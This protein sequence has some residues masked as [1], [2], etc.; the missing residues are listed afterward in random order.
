MST[1][2]VLVAFDGDLGHADQLAGDLADF[3]TRRDPTLPV[4]RRRTDAR[5]QD[6]G[7]TLAIVLGSSAVTTLAA[8]IAAWLRRR[9]DAHL[10]LRRTLPDGQVVQVKLRGQATARTERIVTDFLNG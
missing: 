4:Q 5:S 10:E 3:L 6:F 2:E 1:S 8:G 9:Q 7:A